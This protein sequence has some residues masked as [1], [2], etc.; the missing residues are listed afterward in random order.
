MPKD[1]QYW[2]N[3]A[4]HRILNAEKSSDELVKQMKKLYLQTIDKLNKEIEAFIGR[5][6]TETG[7]S[8]EDV[9]KL[10]TP[11]ELRKF[12]NEALEYYKDLS[13]HA[14]DPNYIKKLK[15]QVYKAT[16]KD[17]R[18]LYSLRRN[19][20]RLE[21]L[22]MQM[23][24]YIENLYMKQNELFTSKLSKVYEDTYMR[25]M[26][27]SQKAVGVY[28]QFN[29]LNTP[30]I[31]RAVQESWLGENYSDRIWNDKNK[32]ISTL[33]TT[34]MQGIAT[35][36]N[37][38]VIASEIRKKTGAKYSNCERLARTEFNHIANQATKE[39]YKSTD[40]LE[41]YKYVATLDSRTSEI[42]QNMSGKI[43][44]L[45]E[46][47]EG[48]N[49]P[50]L[51]SN[52]YDKETEVYTNNGWKLF[53]D[54][55]KDDLYYSLNPETLKAEFV[56]AK[57]TIS[58]K[59]NGEMCYFYNNHFDLLV[60]PNHQIV[61]KYNKKDGSGK[62]RFQ[63]ADKMPK[64]NNSIPRGIEWKGIS[65]DFV[66]LGGYKIPVELY[67]KFMGWYLSEGSCTKIKNINS[68]RV[69][70]AQKK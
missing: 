44:L 40:G 57:E 14:Y 59:Y 67:L 58:Y 48:V 42:C 43:F 50:P 39:S 62:L 18:I 17:G 60:T 32:L 55:T 21:Y 47:Q 20:S 52:C 51:H 5:Y 36:K 19:I 64:T 66:E 34:F 15:S 23:Q 6:S 41:K 35:G 12:R 16:T 26:F 10:L 68:Y 63:N 31:Q 49:Y 2:I 46:A 25:S 65:V 37:P 4:E 9:H 24:F 13:K 53:K 45:K 27:D 38:R 7:L 30:V 22:K 29:A 11:D 33:E 54:C 28:S 70:I 69:K 3:R 8:I 56:N 61:L 1:E